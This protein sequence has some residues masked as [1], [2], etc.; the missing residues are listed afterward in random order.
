MPSV[1][2]LHSKALKKTL[3]AQLQGCR[4]RQRHDVNLLLACY[5]ISLNWII[6]RGHSQVPQPTPVSR[7]PC[8]EGQ[9][10][11]FSEEHHRSGVGPKSLIKPTQIS[12][13]LYN[14]CLKKHLNDRIN[15]LLSILLPALNK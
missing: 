4:Q 10:S 2:A 15:G 5:N 11:N 6:G 3:R 1:K 9:G 7:G 8:L 12:S 14:K 13:K